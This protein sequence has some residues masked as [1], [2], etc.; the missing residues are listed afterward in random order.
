MRNGVCDVN[1]L[2]SHAGE[3]QRLMVGPTSFEEPDLHSTCDLRHSKCELRH[4][5]WGIAYVINSLRGVAYAALE[6]HL[7]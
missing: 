3:P 4:A 1:V 6:L 2:M 7:Q 5:A